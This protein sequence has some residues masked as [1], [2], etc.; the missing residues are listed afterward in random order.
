MRW[1]KTRIWLPYEDQFLIFKDVSKN[2]IF[3]FH[4]KGI[5][6]EDGLNHPL[7]N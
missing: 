2:E 6:N 1:I 3:T 7:L 5:W 4:K